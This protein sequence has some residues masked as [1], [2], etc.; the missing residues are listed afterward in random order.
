MPLPSGLNDPLGSV[1]LTPLEPSTSLLT[2]RV[3]LRNNP[4]FVIL[5][6]GCTKAMG[7]RYAVNRLI[8]ACK[9]SPE[10]RS[11][12]FSFEP[13]HSTFSFANSET[14]VVR[15]R[16]HIHIRSELSPTGW[17]E[18]TVDVLDQGRVPILFSIEQ[19]RNLRFTLEHTPMGDFISCS[20]FG[21]KRTPLPVSTCR[22]PGPGEDKPAAQ[23]QF[24][25]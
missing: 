10:Y 24:L 4:S 2:E 8:R 20:G 5:D 17:I 16:L 1:F 13:C 12:D 6:S 21:M 3:D 14:S 22:S 23:A 7:S 25:C 19:M 15:E 18:T 11:I 9:D